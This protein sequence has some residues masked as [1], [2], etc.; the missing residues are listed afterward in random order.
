MLRGSQVPFSSSLSAQVMEMVRK[1]PFGSGL[2][3][4][5]RESNAC[6]RSVRVSELTHAAATLAYIVA[7]AR[8]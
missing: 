1:E 6:S 4:S 3:V 8:V 7:V 5:G 2:E